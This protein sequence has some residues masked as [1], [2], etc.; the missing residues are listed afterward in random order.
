MYLHMLYISLFII[1]YFKNRTASLFLSLSI[2]VYISF[3][4]YIQSLIQFSLYKEITILGIILFQL[5]Q[6]WFICYEYIE[7][8]FFA[9]PSWGVHKH[10]RPTVNHEAVPDSTTGCLI[11]VSKSRCAWNHWNG[12]G[13]GAELAKDSNFDHTTQKLLFDNAPMS[14]KQS[15]SE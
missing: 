9:K 3:F 4:M 1:I 10:C 12:R 7:N 11:T 13:H 6:Y 8:I 15:S 5:M 2:G 14:P